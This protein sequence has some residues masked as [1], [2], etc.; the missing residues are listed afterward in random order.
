M[1]GGLDKINTYQS[2]RGSMVWFDCKKRVK[3]VNTGRVAGFE[4]P[5]IRLASSSITVDYSLKRSEDLS[6]CF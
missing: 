4:K 3:R 2:Q 1:V 5:G 6:K